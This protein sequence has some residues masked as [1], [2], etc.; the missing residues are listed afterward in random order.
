MEQLIIRLGSDYTSPVQWIVWSAQEQDIIASGELAD[1]GQLSSLTERAGNRA[2]IV[3]VPTSDVV[4]KWV[5]LPPKASR[6]VI[7]AIPFMLEDDLAEDIQSLFFAYGPKQN[8]KQAVAIVKHSKMC[9]WQ[10]WL[11]DANL[12]C[13][14]LIPDVL[15]VPYHK[16]EWSCVHIG[17]SLIVR[18]DSW[19]GM[20][21]E[22]TWLLP[23]LAFYTKQQTSPIL[24]NNYSDQSLHAL[25]NIEEKPQPLD[26]AMGVLAKQALLVRTNLLQGKYKIKNKHLGWMYVWRIPATLAAL[27]LI[28]AIIDRSMT[29][30]HLKQQNDALSTQITRVVD[31]GFPNIGTYRDVRIKVQGEMAK[32]QQGGSGVSLL[33]MLAQLDTAFIQSKVKPQTLRFDASRTELRMQ[34]EGANFNALEIFKKQAEGAGFMIEQGAINNRDDKV[35]GTMV[36]RSAS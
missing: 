25:T 13:E 34:A 15:A 3:L 14:R 6:K 20:E 9:Q 27:V 11:S 12:I 1:A 28:S 21:G 32:L 35:V 17:D 30:T 2:V 19:Q 18:Q 31:Q 24:I 23:A 4:L 33:A 5:N 10:Q 7:N 16:D 26:M 8:N 36:I 22:S 29:Y